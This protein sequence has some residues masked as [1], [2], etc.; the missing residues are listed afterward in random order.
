[1][2]R[3][4]P[5]G[6]SENLAQPQVGVLSPGSSL[7]HRRRWSTL[8]AHRLR[9]SAALSD[10]ESTAY[11]DAARRLHTLRSVMAPSRTRGIGGQSFCFAGT[12]HAAAGEA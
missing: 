10:G 2:L 6:P 5:A 3:I 1:M 4:D 8:R 12:A 7:C 11:L 9:G